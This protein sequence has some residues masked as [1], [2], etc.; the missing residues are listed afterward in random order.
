METTEIIKRLQEKLGSAV[1]RVEAE[2]HDP[3]AVI[4]PDKLGAAAE[5]L[6]NDEE[7]QMDS[8]MNLS[9]VHDLKAKQ[10]IVVYHLFSYTH[11]HKVTLKVELDAAENEHPEVPTV[12]HI[13]RIAE[14]HE[15][16]AWD[17][18]GIKF[19]GHPDLRRLLLPDDWEGHP[20]RK[21]YQAAKYYHGIEIYPER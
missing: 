19:S 9:G 8:L 20:L 14:W 21:D 15:R 16:E 3:F 7:L 18:F 6:R 13:W 5:F 2:V 10:L 12:S 4:E 17:L 11:R 1:Q